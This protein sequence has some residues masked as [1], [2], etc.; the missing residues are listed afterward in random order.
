MNVR[1]W[2][3]KSTLIGL[4]IVSVTKS[5][6]EKLAKELMKQGHVSEKEGRKFAAQIVKE[7]RKQGAQLQ[8][9]VDREVKK[10][11]KKGKKRK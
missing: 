2:L 4:G 6:A 9:V 5:K 7:T 10:A 11:L 8:K 3:R 1:S